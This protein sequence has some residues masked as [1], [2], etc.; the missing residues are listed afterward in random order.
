LL[1]WLIFYGLGVL[2]SIV[3]HQWLT[4]LCWVEEK[5]YGLI[6][7]VIG[8]LTLLVWTLMWIVAAEAGTDFAKLHFGRKSFRQFLF[9]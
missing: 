3:A 6:S 2:V 5:I 8:F 7:L 1:P 4:T 9:T